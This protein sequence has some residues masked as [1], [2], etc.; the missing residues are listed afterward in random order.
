MTQLLETL[1][2]IRQNTSASQN[3]RHKAAGIDKYIESQQNSAMRTTRSASKDQM[4]IGSFTKDVENIEDGPYIQG[5]AGT[6]DHLLVV[7]PLD[8]LDPLAWNFNF[9]QTW[10]WAIRHKVGALQ[11]E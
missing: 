9:G 7:S 2:P 6:A 11:L 8:L 4:Q 10:S 5:Q 1:G 3:I